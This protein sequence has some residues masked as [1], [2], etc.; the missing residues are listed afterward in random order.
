M[1]K[2]WIMSFIRFPMLMIGL[3]IFSV[4]FMLMGWDFRFPF[5]NDISPIYFTIVNALCFILLRH[6]LIKDGRSLKELTGFQRDLFLERCSFWLLMAASIIYTFS[7]SDYHNHVNH[8]WSGFL[9]A[10]SN[11]IRGGYYF[12]TSPVVIMVISIGVSYFPFFKCTN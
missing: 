12:F 7:N 3:L 6:L 2:A 5:L 1:K 11:N 10:F 9:P 4:L 8:V